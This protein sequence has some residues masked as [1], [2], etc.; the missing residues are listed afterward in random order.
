M[1]TQ[2]KIIKK[3]DPSVRRARRRVKMSWRRY[4]EVHDLLNLADNYRLLGQIRKSVLETILENNEEA[5]A[6]FL[7]AAELVAMAIQKHEEILKE[8]K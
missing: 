6:A 8:E 4:D 5:K 1:P 3:V 7:K 2:K